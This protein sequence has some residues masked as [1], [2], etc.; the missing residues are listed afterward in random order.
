[1]KKRHRFSLQKK[2]VL[3]TTTLALI[4]YSV[5]GFFIYAVFDMVKDYIAISETLF[6]IITLLL[7]IIWSG[8]LAFLA[9]RFITRPLQRLEEAASKAANGDLNQSIDIPKSEDEIRSLSIAVNTM[10]E[11]I[12][13][14][15]HNIDY[16]FDNTS[17]TVSD[18]KQVANA[19]SK[20]AVT[21]TSATED[22][23]SGAMSAADAMQNTAEAVEEATSLAESVQLK[24]EQSTVKSTSMLNTLTDSKDIVHQLVSGI[25]SLAQEQ[26]ISLNDVEKLKANAQQVE[27]IISMVGDIAE[28]TNLL[29]LNASIEAARAGE[30][31]QGFAVVAD[32][33][34]KLADESA[35][36]VQQISLLIT[37]IQDDVTLVVDKINGH[38]TH[39]RKEAA[40]GE[41]TNTAIEEM[42]HSVTEVADEIAAI[43]GLVDR[44]LHFIQSTVKQ[45]QEVAAI[46]EETSAA[47]QE[48]GAVIQEQESTIQQADKLASELENQASE[49]KKQIQQFSV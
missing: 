25:Q 16:H 23:S 13:T 7:G 33:I 42:S 40:K 48:V 34:R 47:T 17:Q 44:Q 29:A 39:A 49:L 22:I 19:A 45:S 36:A 37:T 5:S 11:N 28:Q 38:V 6:V 3:F 26:E 31:G 9:A 14:M 27:A 4:T 46:A 18:M 24:L 12:Q 20:H 41:T 2:L 8:I 1:M 32:E 43:S 15:V 30:H 21:I 10:F 35:K